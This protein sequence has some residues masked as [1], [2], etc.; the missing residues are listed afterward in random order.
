[1]LF[2]QLKETSITGELVEENTIRILESARNASNITTPLNR[3]QIVGV[4]GVIGLLLGI[5]LAFLFE[6]F[7]KTVK[8]PD[9]IET[10]LGLS[11]LGTI[12]K[13]DRKQKKIGGKSSPSLQAKKHYAL[14]GGK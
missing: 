1:M 6:Y 12:P 4:G 2:R 14:E 3:G 8:T 11:V 13:I 7:D 9:D 5:G 10:H